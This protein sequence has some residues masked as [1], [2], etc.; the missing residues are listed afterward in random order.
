MRGSGWCSSC[1]A[2]VS[3]EF[4]ATAPTRPLDVVVGSAAGIF[5]AN[6]RCE[7]FE[8][9]D[10]RRARWRQRRALAMRY[11]TPEEFGR[12]SAGRRLG[13][14]DYSPARIEACSCEWR[15]T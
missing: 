1:L 5:V 12:G 13:D 4:R 7:E 10:M 8:G 2:D 14:Q 9:I 3:L 11:P 15:Y 6:R